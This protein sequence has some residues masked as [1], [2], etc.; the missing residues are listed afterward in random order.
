MGIRWGP[1][2]CRPVIVIVAVV[3]ILVVTVAIPVATMAT[4]AG[5]ATGM[6][7]VSRKVDSAVGG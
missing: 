7:V 6:G 5:M 3:A 4:A 1:A 2:L